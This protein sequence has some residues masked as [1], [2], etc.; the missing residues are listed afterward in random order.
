M[1]NYYSKPTQ[2][3]KSSPKT[4]QYNWLRNDLNHTIHRNGI[5]ITIIMAKH[6]GNNV[7]KLE[8]LLCFDYEN[9]IID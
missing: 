7:K 6:F 3:E 2:I 8:V 4:H 1:E 5:V 9:G